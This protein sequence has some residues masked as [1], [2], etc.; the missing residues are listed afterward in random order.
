MNIECTGC[1]LIRFTMEQEGKNKYRTITCIHENRECPC[2]TCLVKITCN[3]LDNLKDC[4]EFQQFNI[5]YPT[6]EYWRE[7]SENA[8]KIQI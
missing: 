1:Y 4:E 6:N 3:L 8:N 2:K 7:R 5:K